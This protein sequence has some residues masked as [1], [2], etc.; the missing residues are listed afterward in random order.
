MFA[1]LKA[2]NPRPTTELNYSTSFELLVA[3]ILSA[4]ATD[5][6]VNK[7][8]AVL[9]PRANTPEAILRLGV[10]GL[11]KYIKS[12]GLYNSKAG[13]IIKTCR[14]LKNTTVRCR[15]IGKHCRRCPE[16]AGKPPTSY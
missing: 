15:P 7:A 2:A 6:S 3:V 11:K 12:I 5:V 10:N 1:E 16:S 4:Q 13:N 8:L 14:I 9:F